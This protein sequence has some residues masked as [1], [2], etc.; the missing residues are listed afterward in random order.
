MTAATIAALVA[1]IG[2]PSSIAG[3]EPTT[4]V[5]R[6]RLIVTVMLGC[7]RRQPARAALGALLLGARDYRGGGAQRIISADS[8]ALTSGILQALGGEPRHGHGGVFDAGFAAASAGT[9]AVGALLDVMG[10]QSAMSWAAAFALMSAANVLGAWAIV[11]E[12][13]SQKPKP[14]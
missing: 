14:S 11:R 13:A 3:A 6:R 10:G 5:E 2:V 8:A 1:M 12:L 4:R 9:F 7:C